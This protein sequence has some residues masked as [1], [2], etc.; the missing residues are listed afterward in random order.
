MYLLIVQCP[1]TTT[2]CYLHQ[3]FIFYPDLLV[4]LAGLLEKL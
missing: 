3:K 2:I 4:G 1:I